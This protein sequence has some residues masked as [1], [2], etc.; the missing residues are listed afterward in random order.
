MNDMNIR[1]AAY[2]I[3]IAAFACA[4]AGFFTLAIYT[5]AMG[6]IL[7]AFCSTCLASVSTLRCRHLSK[8]GYMNNQ[9]PFVWT[10]YMAVSVLHFG[11]RNVGVPEELVQYS[12]IVLLFTSV[13]ICQEIIAYVRK[14]PPTASEV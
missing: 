14:N 2:K 1:C 11:Y 7:V 8:H 6:Q 10:F 9:D 13:P 5:V 12:I 3:Q 4:A